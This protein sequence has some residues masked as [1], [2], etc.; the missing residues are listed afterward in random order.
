MRILSSLLAAASL[1]SL[2]TAQTLL[3]D[4]AFRLQVGI[5]DTPALEEGSASWA[6]IDNDGDVDLL[7][8]GLDA[9]TGL[10]TT[11]LLRNPLVGGG[12]G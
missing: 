12:S 10:L 5:L 2:A 1:T 3:G 6:D 11:Q 9:S 4:S 8:S 7:L